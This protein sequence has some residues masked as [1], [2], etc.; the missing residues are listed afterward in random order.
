MQSNI[1]PV[2]DE[3]IQS[4]V[5][6]HKDDGEEDFFPGLLKIILFFYQV[7]V[8]FKINVGSRSDGFVHLLQEVVSILFNPRTDGTFAQNFS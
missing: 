3:E 7:N 5:A 4:M 2:S 6:L 8:L 1:E